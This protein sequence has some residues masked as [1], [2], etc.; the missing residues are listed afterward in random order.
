MLKYILQD[1]LF[2]LVYFLNFILFFNLNFFFFFLRLI[3]VVTIAGYSSGQ[4][5]AVGDSADDSRVR[6]TAARTGE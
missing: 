2:F 3:F 1:E 5:V 4:H 6:V